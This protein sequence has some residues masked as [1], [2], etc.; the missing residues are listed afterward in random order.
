MDHFAALSSSE[1]LDE[2]SM[3]LPPPPSRTRKRDLDESDDTDDVSLDSDAPWTVDKIRAV[4]GP[5]Q[6][7]L[8]RVRE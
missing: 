5:E 4:A 1:P 6:A 8:E 2:T 7:D 3:H